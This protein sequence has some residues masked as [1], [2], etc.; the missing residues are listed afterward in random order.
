M[1]TNCEPT[2]PAATVVVRVT[3]IPVPFTILPARAQPG[4]PPPPCCPTLVADWTLAVE[5]TVGGTLDFTSATVR[6]SSTG[7]VL[8]SSQFDGATSIRAGQ[9][10]TFQQQLLGRAASGFTATDPLIAV[11]EAHFTFSNRERLVGTVEIPLVAR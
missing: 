11:V 3:P 7:T 9:E 8:L 2:Q 5:A 1:L 4:E 6:N 10:I